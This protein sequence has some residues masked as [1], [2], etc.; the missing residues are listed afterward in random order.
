MTLELIDTADRPGVV[1]P[2]IDPGEATLL[3]TD[4]LADEEP[5]IPRRRKST[6]RDRRSDGLETGTRRNGDAIAA[7]FDTD[8]QERAT[9]AFLGGD[10]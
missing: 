8:T 7:C 10:A 4:R 1:R 2:R 5:E 3:P 9:G 6:L